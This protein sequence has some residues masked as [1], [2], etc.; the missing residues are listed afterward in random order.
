[1]CQG[2][3]P[4]DTQTNGQLTVDNIDTVNAAYEYYPDGKLKKGTYPKLADGTYLTAEYEYNKLDKVT[5]V[6]NKKGTTILAEYNYD[7]DVN[8]NVNSVTDTTGTTTYIYDKLDRLSEVHRPDTS[9]VQYIVT[10]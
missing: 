7:Y 8:E 10:T 4:L 3:C 1:M 5:K 9:T 2:T 6:T